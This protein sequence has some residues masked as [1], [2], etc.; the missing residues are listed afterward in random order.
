MM[1][2]TNLRVFANKFKLNHLSDL[3]IRRTDKVFENMILMGRVISPT[4][5]FF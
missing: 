2:Y 1:L 3:H 5:P 4:L